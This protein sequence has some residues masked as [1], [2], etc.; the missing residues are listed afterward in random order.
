MTLEVI[1][2]IRHGVSSHVHALLS[3][4]LEYVHFLITGSF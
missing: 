4:F 2:L 1:Y 3:C